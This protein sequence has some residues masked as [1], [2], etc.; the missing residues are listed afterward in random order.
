MQSYKWH[1]LSQ[2]SSCCAIKDAFIHAKK[3]RTTF[4]MNITHSIVMYVKSRQNLLILMPRDLE[5]NHHQLPKLA[6]YRSYFKKKGGNL[7]KDWLWR[8]SYFLY[9]WFLTSCQLPLQSTWRENYISCFYILF[10]LKMLN[11]IWC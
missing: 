10:F 5:K 8:E 1:Q 7:K 3:S 6:Q 4:E 2:R 11:C 9:L